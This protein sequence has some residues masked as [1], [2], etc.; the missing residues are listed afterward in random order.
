MQEKQDHGDMLTSGLEPNGI[1]FGSRKMKTFTT[2][3]LYSER[4]ETE[5]HFSE[6]A[7]IAQVQSTF[8]NGKI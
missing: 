7:L 5:N 4:N 1:P 6:I 8:E 2:I 3:T